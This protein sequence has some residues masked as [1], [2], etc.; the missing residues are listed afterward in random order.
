MQVCTAN[1]HTSTQLKYT[2]KVAYNLKR[3]NK[4]KWK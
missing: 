4:S 1:A 2:V 3:V